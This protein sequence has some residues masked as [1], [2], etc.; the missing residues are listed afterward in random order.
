MKRPIFVR[1]LTDAER[2]ALEAGLRSPEAFTLRRVPDPAGQLPAASTPRIARCLGCNPT[3]R[4][5]RHPRLQR[6]GHERRCARA[7]PRPTSGPCRL[8]RRGRGRAAAR[9]APPS[10]AGF[11]KADEPVDAWIWRPRRRS[12]KGLTATR[13]SGETVRATLERL[14]VRLAA[15]QALDHQPRPGV[16]AKKRRRDRLIR[17]AASHPDWALGFEDETWWSR[18]AL[19]AMHAWS[20]GGQPLRLVE[21]AVA[22]EDP[23]PKALACYGLLACRSTSRIWLRFVTGRPV[24]GVTTRFLAWSCER[25]A[26]AGKTALLLVWDNAAWH[27]SKEVGG[28][29]ASTTGRSRRWQAGVRI[30]AASCRSRARGSTRSSRSGR[31][32]S[33]SGGGRRAAQ[34]P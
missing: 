32:A 5:A 31:T 21:Q 25:L 29:S 27:V 10:P 8:R 33:A 4:C 34:C 13:V 3:R 2:E 17:L 11:G 14:G 23:D 24:S 16:R 26:A 22:K 6:G 18:L 19:P 20:R 7:L 9:A 30:V 15:R 1:P 12:R 28:G